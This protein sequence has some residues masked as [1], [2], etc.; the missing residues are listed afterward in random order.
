M[1]AIKIIT[2]LLIFFF[3]LPDKAC[4]QN[5]MFKQKKERKKIWRRWRKNRE[6]Y[7]P[8][9]DRKAKNKPSARMARGDKKE[10]RR[11]KRLAKKQMRRGKRAVNN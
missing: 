8:Y 1:R 2:V 4:A 10:L 5:E 6:A 9:L 11:Q 7:N 3:F